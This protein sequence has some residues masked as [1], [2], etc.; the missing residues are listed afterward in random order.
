M[1]DI[2]LDNADRQ[3]EWVENAMTSSSKY[4][5]V[6]I[7]YD[8]KGKTMQTRRYK[9]VEDA[10]TRCGPARKRQSVSEISVALVDVLEE[11]EYSWFP[12]KVQIQDFQSK[13]W[14]TVSR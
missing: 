7:Q 6:I 10:T 12:R 1:I 13:K 14:L 3:Y 2:R 5:N 4:Q 9:R 8:S 11:M